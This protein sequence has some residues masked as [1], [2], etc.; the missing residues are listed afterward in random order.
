MSK[1]YDEQLKDFVEAKSAVYFKYNYDTLSRWLLKVAFNSE[2]MGV[3]EYKSFY[4]DTLINYILNGGDIQNLL[5]FV[6]LISP[7]TLI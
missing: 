7:Y 6:Q 2:R 1:L 5:L 3:H 4:N